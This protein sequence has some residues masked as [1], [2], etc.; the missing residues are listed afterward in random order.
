MSIL[1]RRSAALLV[2]TSLF[3][4]MSLKA[5]SAPTA[6]ELVRQAYVRLAVADH[7]YKGHRVSAMKH[8]EAAGKFL[9]LNLRGEGRGRE[10]QGTSDM[11]LRAASDLLSQASAG[12]TGKPLKRVQDAL[13]QISIA[14]SIK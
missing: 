13:R 10:M 8:L 12:L 7:D 14:L 3:I 11:Q 9:G 5:Q 4:S 6:A 2:I 1:L